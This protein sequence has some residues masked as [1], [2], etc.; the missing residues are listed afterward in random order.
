ME[1][2]YKILGYLMEPFEKILLMGKT[3]VSEEI[4]EAA[5]NAHA[6]QFIMQ[7]KNGL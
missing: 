3:P 7:L 2:F 5:K 6:H 4:I 1:W